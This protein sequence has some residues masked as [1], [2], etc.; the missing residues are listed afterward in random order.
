MV[1]KPLKHT[2]QVDDAGLAQKK[3]I[4]SRTIA[5]EKPGA[6]AQAHRH[7]HR[8]RFVGTYHDYILKAPPHLLAPIMT[9]A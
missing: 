7:R 5:E 8:H 3:A 2:V 1:A 4:V 6:Q 9:T